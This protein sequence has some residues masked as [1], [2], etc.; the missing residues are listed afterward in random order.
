MRP[1][2]PKKPQ[3]ATPGRPPKLTPEIQDRI[4]KIILAGAPMSIACGAVGIPDR[5]AR[6]WVRKGREEQAAGGGRH[7]DFLDAVSFA[8]SNRSAGYAQVITRAA[9]QGDWKA[10]GWMLEKTEP[11]LFGFKG[12]IH[13]Q[14]RS[15]REQL[16]DVAQK[17]LPRA[18]FIRLLNALAEADENDASIPDGPASTE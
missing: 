2:K 8:K 17:T 14:L 16:L 6:I 11:K 13:M 3:N 12:A 5:T 7:A 4:C 1:R 18:E 10:A 15:D 9:V